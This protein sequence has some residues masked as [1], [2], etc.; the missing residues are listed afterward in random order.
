MYRYDHKIGMNS[1]LVLTPQPLRVPGYCRHAGGRQEKSPGNV[2]RKMVISFMTRWF[3]HCGTQ[4]EIFLD[5]SV[6]IMAVDALVPCTALLSR[7]TILTMQTNGSSLSFTGK[8]FNYLHLLSAERKCGISSYPSENK[9]TL[10]S[11]WLSAN[12]RQ[13]SSD[14]MLKDTHRCNAWCDMQQDT[15][16][17]YLNLNRGRKWYAFERCYM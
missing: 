10:F 6:N 15:E 8:N 11:K 4:T 9:W 14:P 1:L 17:C 2:V 13:A 7:T 16:V 12:R 5:N 3:N